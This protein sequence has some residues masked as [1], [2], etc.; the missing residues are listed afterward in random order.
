MTNVAVAAEAK[1]EHPL[2]KFK[3]QVL[4]RQD[5]FRG[6]LPAHIPVERFMRCIL[7][8]VQQNPYLLTLDR[9]S[10]FAAAMKAAADG[11]LCDGREAALVPFKKQ[12]QYM[13]MVA[14]ILKKCRNSGELSSIVAKVVYAGDKFR[15]WIDDAGEHI[16]YEAGE[17]QDRG[18]VR[19]VF[20]MAK[21]KDGA[22]EVEVLKPADIEKIRSVSR[23]KDDGPW[24]MWWD[25]MAQKSAIR[26]LAKRLPLNT[27]QDDLIRR[28]DALY[29]LDGAAAEAKTAISGKRSL[30]E[31]F[32][33]IA[34]PSDLEPVI[35]TIDADT[36]EIITETAASDPP[37]QAADDAGPAVTSSQTAGSA[38][39][40]PEPKK[41]KQAITS[42]RSPAADQ[43]RAEILASLLQTGDERAL[44][45]GMAGVKFWINNDCTANEV[46]L[47]MPE[48]H[49]RWA[50]IAEGGKK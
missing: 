45:G 32:D 2:V 15:N 4:S 50:K 41:A 28:D 27:D 29:D 5:E 14:G 23:A 11:L 24:T 13:P 35:D 42:G 31:K 37:T 3:G 25:Q 20:A 30:A 10:L 44:E 47:F 8:A 22:V 9:P 7:T 17:N 49:D 33:L 39:T 6:A 38:S 36:G 12:V 43:K 40:T 1:P 21:L 48:H 46:A 16:E 34:G 26:R 19:S 18:M